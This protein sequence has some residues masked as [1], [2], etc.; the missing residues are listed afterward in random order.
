MTP[1]DKNAD[2]L[3][4]FPPSLKIALES[5][6]CPIIITDKEGKI[7]YA[8]SSVERVT[9]F[10]HREMIGNT[11]KIWG[12]LMDKKFYD[13]L[14]Q[15]IYKHK[16]T[17][18]GEITNKKKNG[19]IY[20]ARVTITPITDNSGSIIGFAGSEED[21]TEYKTLE[22]QKTEF[23]SIA[24]H[25]LRTPLGSMRWNLEMLLAGDIG[26]VP[27]PIKKILA[28]IYESN[29]RMIILVNDLLSVTRIE[30]GRVPNEPEDVDPI[31]AI[32]TVVKDLSGEAKKH[33][34]RV[35][36][37]I[38]SKKIPRLFIDPKQFI[39]VFKNLVS[40]AIKYSH[41]LGTV[42]ITLVLKG[43]MLNIDVSDSGIGIPKK[44][45]PRIFSKYFRAENAVKNMN[46]GTGLGLFVVKSF[47]VNWG[48]RVSFDSKMGKG[49]VFSVHIP[50]LRKK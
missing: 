42:T 32:K 43:N 29:L 18:H 11:P 26:E 31:E 20:K 1:E 35:L 9:G 30:Q 39:E 25:Q 37:R 7:L 47:V 41:N 6:Y 2:T 19:Q 45:Q 38:P 48:G 3:L 17:F 21:L 33:S 50:I 23:L 28:Q 24:S 5:S 8:N 44:D 13:N 27:D 49:T 46:E 22:K 40:N 12:G 14:W 36:L 4:N 34:I 10:S 16:L 15:T